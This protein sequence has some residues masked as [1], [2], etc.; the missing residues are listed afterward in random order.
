MYQV[1][2]KAIPFLDNVVRVLDPHLG[3]LCDLAHEAMFGFIE[4]YQEASNEE[5]S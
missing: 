2:E 4:G 3:K 1:E 5:N